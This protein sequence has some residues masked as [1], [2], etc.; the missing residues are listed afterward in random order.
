M[1]SSKGGS[2]EREI[3]KRL[4]LWFTNNK[5]ED[6]FWRSK[7]SGGRGTQRAKNKNKE[8]NIEDFGDIRS[9]LPEGK[10]FCEF[11]CT[12]LKTGY[13]KKIK[14]K[15][16]NKIHNWSVMDHIDAGK[17]QKNFQLFEFWEQSKR[18]AKISKRIPL[19]IFRRQQK[20]AC[21]CMRI[22]LFQL[23]YGWFKTTENKKFSVNFP[24]ILI[25]NYENQDDLVIIGLDDFFSWTQ[26]N[27]NEKFLKQKRKELILCYA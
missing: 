10:P 23:F 2:F 14:T 12:E 8:L 1:S 13:A 20:Q 24:F 15:E 26:G 5:T 22:D 11:F 3:C 19:L 6:A 25:N 27:I 9:D 21:I 16:G 18:D 4:S 17:N 7:S